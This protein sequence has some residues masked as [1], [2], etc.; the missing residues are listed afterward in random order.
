MKE[1]KL[2]KL[3]RER[4]KKDVQKQIELT[5]GFDEKRKQRITQ[6]ISIEILISFI[7]ASL[8]L[9][10]IFMESTHKNSIILLLIFGWILLGITIPIVKWL[11]LLREVG[12]MFEK[13]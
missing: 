11:S 13:S 5:L 7:F 1:K 6:I 10:T 9:L 3:T 12:K 2:S 4:I 8:L